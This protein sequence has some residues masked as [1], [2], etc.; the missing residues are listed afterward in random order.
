ME[1]LEKITVDH[2]EYHDPSL[3]DDSG[4]TVAMHS[5]YYNRLNILPT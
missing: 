1:E 5:S 4:M 3:R 2:P